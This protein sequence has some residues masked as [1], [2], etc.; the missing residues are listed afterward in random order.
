MSK[1]GEPASAGPLSLLAA[2]AGEFGA[3]IERPVGKELFATISLQRADGRISDYRLSISGQ[4]GELKVREWSPRRLPADCPERHINHDGSFCTNWARVEPIVVMDEDSADAFWARLIQY[5]RHQERVEK[6]RRWPSR[7]AWAH[8]A[9]AIHQERAEDCAKALGSG[10]SK[11][12]AR[13]ALTVSRSRGNSGRFLRLMR[14]NKRVYSVWEKEKRVAIKRQRCICGQ[15]RLAVCDCADHARLAV[16]LVLALVEWKRAEERF[17]AVNM[18]APCCGTVDE[19]PRASSKKE[20]K[21][22]LQS[23]A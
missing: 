8:G 7:R 14:D 2:R 19:C 15:T 10:F 6:K 18:D 16:D 17:W 13:G 11:A 3:R 4:A 23:A 5:L 1:T 9:A 20:S 12:L 21:P 22:K